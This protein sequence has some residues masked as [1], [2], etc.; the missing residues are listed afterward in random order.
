[1][2]LETWPMFSAKHAGLCFLALAVAGCGRSAATTDSEEVVTRN[3]WA[4]MELTS[5]GN[6]NTRV[7]VELNENGSLGNNI[8]L[9]ADER[10]EV[11]AQGTVVTL[12]E[13]ED[14][15]DIDY[16]GTVPTDDSGTL[17]RISLYRADGTINNGS[18]INLPDT[19]DIVAPIS[20]QTHRLGSAIDIIWS[21]ANAGNSIE[22]EVAT[23]CSGGAQVAVQFFELADS[24][25]HSFNTNR[26]LIAND[27]NLDRTADCEFD[28]A[29]RRERRGTLDRAFRAGGYVSATQIRRVEGMTLSFQ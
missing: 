9:S 25:A 29:L 20:G 19:F 2:D 6:G 7:K 10:L 5:K 13:D 18:F 21:P 8:R 24:G 16:E 27:S 12:R 22:L 17:F 4:G 1:M 14:F 23:R 26:L 3:L 11:I 28:I 15:G